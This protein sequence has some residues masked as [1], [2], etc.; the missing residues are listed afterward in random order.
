MKEIGITKSLLISVG[1]HLFAFL[2]ISFLL[3]IH[4]FP[5][6]NQSVPVSI[7]IE[8]ESLSAGLGVTPIETANKN[9]PALEKRVTSTIEKSAVPE[10][11][12]PKQDLLKNF[13]K[14]KETIKETIAKDSEKDIHKELQE[15]NPRQDVLS[16]AE[17]PIDKEQKEEA[18]K[19]K[20]NKELNKISGDIDKALE[21]DSETASSS[22]K[23]GNNKGGFNNKSGDPLGD[24]NWSIKPRRTLFFPDIQTK[25]PEKYKKK[26]LGYSITSRIAFDKN[27][28][29]I[30]VD[31]ITSSGDPNIDNIF[32][33]EL[34]KIR[35][36]PI[37]ENRI[38]EI[39]KTFPI[40]LK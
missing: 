37:N 34:R 10:K 13:D 16:S 35:V 26:G 7:D 18:N 17:M 5:L 30:K 8:A 9:A 20:I 15:T 27:G 23:N 19:N 31:I 21:D 36:E 25:I 6:S 38:D 12:I 14:S 33:S 29:A 3:L 39:T 2:I 24:V 22:G 40:S 1:L 4:P 11:T 32:S 28:L